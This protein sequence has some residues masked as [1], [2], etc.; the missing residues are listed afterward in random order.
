MTS[1]DFIKLKE[2]QTF[3][4]KVSEEINTKHIKNYVFTQI[5]SHNLTLNENSKIFYNFINKTNSYQITIINS[6]SNNI[7]LEPYI[8][9]SFYLKKDKSSIDLFVCDEFISLY[10]NTK[11]LYYKEIKNDS[12]KK[13]IIKYIQQTLNIEIDNIYDISAIELEKYKKRYLENIKLFKKIQFLSK[14]NNKNAIFYLT[15]LLVVIAFLIYYSFDVLIQDK[16]VITKNIKN[17]RLEQ[18]KKEYTDLL[19]KYENN[20]KLTSNLLTLFSLLNKNDIKLINLKIMEDKSQIK[21][22]AEKKDV[23]LNFLDFYDEDSTINNMRYIKEENAYEM[24]A[25]VKLHK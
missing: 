24:Y 11:L 16:I 22:K 25:T 14:Q 6:S 8:F 5:Q 15:Y 7:L 9:E 4:S 17:I 13:D 23:L 3:I 1:I 21:M 12:S 2:S 10:E 19:D 20:E 18:I